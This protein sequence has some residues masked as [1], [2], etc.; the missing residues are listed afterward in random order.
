M[1]IT[2]VDNSFYADPQGLNALKRDAHAQAP[3]ALRETARQFE[4]LFTGMMLKSMRAAT[5]KDPLFGSDQ[6]DFYQDM[7]DQQLAAQMSKG[8]GTGLAD[9]L[10]QQLLRSGVTPGASSAA[11]PASDPAAPPTA[12]NW[13]PASREE[14]VQ[15][16]LPA[17]TAAGKQLGV[18]P[19]SLIAHAALET[20]WGKSMPKAAD[21][22]CSYNLFGIKAGGGWTGGE[23]AA[24]T[25][26]VVDGQV[27]RQSAAF[28]RYAS[29]AECIQDY[30]NLLS[31][32]R[33]YAGALDTGSDALAFASALQ[34]G[35][36]ATDPNYANKLSAVAQ[37]LKSS[38]VLPLT[39]SDF[40]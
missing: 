3:S 24:P 23:V 6:T 37:S 1:A 21:G 25:T 8:K 40:S 28:R 13:P 38:S 26:E 22:S 16:L 36:Y 20:G 17:A 34:Q 32:S 5:P 4:T 15:A 14:F 31:G 35:G 19:R 9:M 39:V 11:K 7:F 10:V 30:A 12:L 2:P 29:P 18:D 27:Q 33:R